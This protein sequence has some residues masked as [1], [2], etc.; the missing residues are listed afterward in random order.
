MFQLMANGQNGLSGQS[1]PHYVE[2]ERKFVIDI[3]QPQHPN[4]GA[5]SVKESM[6]RR[7]LAMKTHVPVSSYNLRNWFD[8]GAGRKL[9]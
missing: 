2:V 8:M 9:F 4:L 5:K 1:A 6:R 3:A 7:V